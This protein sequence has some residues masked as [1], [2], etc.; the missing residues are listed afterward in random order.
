MSEIQLSQVEDLNQVSN[1]VG[2]DAEVDEVFRSSSKERLPFAF[3]HR[4]DVVLALGETGE[5][6]LFYT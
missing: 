5:L 2:F 4:H 6:S 1:D 3:A